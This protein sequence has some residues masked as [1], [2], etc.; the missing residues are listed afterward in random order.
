MTTAARAAAWWGAAP[1]FLSRVR[2][3][4][5]AAL[6][7]LAVVAPPTTPGR[8]LAF[9][10]GVAILGL[11]PHAP[12][13]VGLAGLPLC[14]MGTWPGGYVPRE[15]GAAVVLFCLF[16]AIGYAWPGWVGAVSTVGYA[17]TETCCSV[18]LG[19]HGL[20]VSAMRGLAEGWIAMSRNILLPEGARFADW[21]PGRAL[22]LISGI[23]V[24]VIV[25]G[26]AAILGYSFSSRA[27]ATSQLARTQAMLGQLTREQEIAH[28]I[29]D[30]VA[31]DVSVIAMLA[32]RARSVDDDGEMLDAIYALAHQALDR[33]HE[34]I[35]VLNG[36][37]PLDGAAAAASTDSSAPS[38]PSAPSGP[39]DPSGSPDPSDPSASSA[40]ADRTA[41]GDPVLAAAPLDEAMARYCEGQDRL[42]H[43]LGCEGQAVVS[44]VA[45]GKVRPRARR[46]VTDLVEE[47]YANIVRHCEP[48]SGFAYGVFVTFDGDVARI[49]STNPVG[50]DGPRELRRVRHGKGLALQRATVESLGGTLNTAVQDG[51]WVLG[52][53]VPLT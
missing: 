6:M 28:M 21:A 51:A 44:G 30:S 34:V 12:R 7:L 8:M 14:L 41:A 40:P 10:G 18:F 42:M 26:F 48:G 35:D 16:V 50:G 27:E 46:C 47:A 23:G 32:W 20:A 11:L 22:L 53:A 3:A 36:T 37:R 13:L 52:A 4:G 39:S 25:S 1:V 33:T 19:A 38:A 24:S 49:T 17:V 31:N 9:F 2:I 29:H 5:V 15:L 43:M 45:P